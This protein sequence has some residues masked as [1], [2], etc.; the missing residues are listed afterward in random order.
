[1]TTLVLKHSEWL[2]VRQRMDADYGKVNTLISWRLQE[3]LG[4]TV[5]YHTGYSVWKKQYEDDI[6]LD[7]INQDS[8]TFF[9]LKYGFTDA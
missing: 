7:F 6:R 2:S 5:R 4:F 8:L 9:K 3:L 1:M